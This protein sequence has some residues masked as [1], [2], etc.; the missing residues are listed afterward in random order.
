MNHYS[1]GCHNGPRPC[2]GL[3]DGEEMI[4]ALA[5]ATPCSEN[6]RSWVLG[7]EQKDATIELHRLFI[8]DCTPYNTESWF[9][10]RCLKM[11]KADRPQTR[12]VVSFSDLTEG[13]A[14]TIYAATNFIKTGT[15]KKKTFYR[16]EQGR[17]RHPR[18][19]GVNITREEA[20]RKGWTAERRDSKTRWHIPLG[21]TKK[22]TKWLK[23]RIL[24]KIQ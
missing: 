10:S 24:E 17:L 4:G 2:Y 15:T 12:I 18:Q 14:G 13:H 21:R 6:V 19:C 8:H 22:E 11:L 16:D 5:F 3:F 1:K 7:P 20:K 9:I 23:C